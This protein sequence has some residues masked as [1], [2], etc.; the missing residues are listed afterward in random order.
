MSTISDYSNSISIFSKSC[1]VHCPKWASSFMACLSK[2]IF[3]ILLHIASELRAWVYASSIAGFLLSLLKSLDCSQS[4]I[5]PW[6]H[7]CWSFSSTGRHRVSWCERN[8]GEYKMPLGTGGGG[9]N[10]VGWGGG[11]NR[12]PCLPPPLP[13]GIFYPHLGSH[14][15]IR[16]CEQSIKSPNELACSE[17]YC[18][19]I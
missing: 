16:D 9:A 13:T 5:F 11:K 1:T 12:P 6:D 8:W 3:F 7:R 10:S 2:T 15:K 18:K 19:I 4:P 14:G 17:P